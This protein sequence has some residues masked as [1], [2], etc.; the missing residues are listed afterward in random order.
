MLKTLVSAAGLASRRCSGSGRRILSLGL[1]I[2]L[3][4]LAFLLALTVRFDL[5]LHTPTGTN[6]LLAYFLPLV[7]IVVGIKL[8]VFLAMGI[9]R[10]TWR[11]VSLDDLLTLFG[12]SQVS[13]LCL[14]VLFYSLQYA[15]GQWLGR[16][17]WAGLPESVFL[18]DWVFGVLLI[19]G[20]RV[21]VRLLYE[22]G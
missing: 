3:L 20:A 10:L 12:G 15:A 19:G 22:E 4:S 2:L 17:L 5:Q 21:V 18:L 13:L 9:H 11:Y 6:W 16:P 8:I 7:G 1:Q 14:F